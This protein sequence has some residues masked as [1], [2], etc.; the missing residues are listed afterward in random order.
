MKMPDFNKVITAIAEKDWCVDPSFITE[1]ESRPLIRE[2]SALS[3][4]GAF[5]PAGIGRGMGAAMRPDIRGDKILWLDPE[6]PT[7]AQ[8]AF[9]LKLET[10]R[11]ACN[12]ELFTGLSA[13]EA[14][15]ACYPPGAGYARHLDRF[16]DSD[17]RVISFVLYL[18][19]NWESHWGGQLRMYLPEGHVDVQPVAGTLVLFRSETVYHEVLPSS[20]YRYTLTG[21]FRRRAM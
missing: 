10:L 13:L 14:H 8:S 19:P 11:I 12:R 3:D 2:A 7:T 4:A 6:S 1:T 18:N 17:T 5:R 9:F 15:Y 20:A 16:S 21:W